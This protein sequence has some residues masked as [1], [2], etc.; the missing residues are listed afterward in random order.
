MKETETQ[1]HNA[2]KIVMN[3]KLQLA[4]GSSRHEKLGK[5]IVGVFGPLAESQNAQLMIIVDD[6]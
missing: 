5:K 3:K 6:G 4:L 1:K 2:L